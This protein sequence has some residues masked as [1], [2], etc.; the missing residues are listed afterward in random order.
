MFSYA[1]LTVGALLLILGVVIVLINE[2][3]RHERRD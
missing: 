1:Q 2:R 3:H